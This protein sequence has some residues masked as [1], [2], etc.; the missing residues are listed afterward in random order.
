MKHAVKK[1]DSRP[2]K[3]A[4]NIKMMVVDPVT[5][6]KAKF[7]SKKTI[8]EAYKKEN[9]KNLNINLNNSNLKYRFNKHNILQFY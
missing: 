4:K 2:F 3:V 7:G 8:I 9:I 6:E 5:G 1:K